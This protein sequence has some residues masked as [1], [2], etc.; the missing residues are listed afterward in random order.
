MRSNVRADALGCWVRVMLPRLIS[1]CL[2]PCSM[3]RQSLSTIERSSPLRVRT[4][5]LES[6]RHLGT[7]GPLAV[8][9]TIVFV[10]TE[11]AGSRRRWLR[12]GK[13]DRF[14]PGTP[15]DP[16]A[17]AAVRPLRPRDGYCAPHRQGRAQ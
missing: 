2:R 17:D 6:Q 11:P 14:V 9:T 7:T 16:D 12:T 1:M 13:K 3:T 10:L 15:S 5:I 4:V 8:S